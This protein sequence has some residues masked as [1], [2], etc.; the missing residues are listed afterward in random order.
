MLNSF[1]EIVINFFSVFPRDLAVFLLSMFP[2]GELKLSLPVGLLVYH[3]PIWQVVVLSIVGN[4]IPTTVI[5]F[6]ADRFHCW[7]EK[8]SGFF[9]KRWINTLAKIQKKFSGRYEKYGLIIL[10]LITSIPVPGSGAYAGALAALVF[11]ISVKKSLP[12]IFSGILLSTL[13]IILL[14]IGVD[15]VF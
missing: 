12:C 7:V 5:L 13:I 14:T 11:G 2:V 10:V 9:S 15:K 8:R 4:M 6:F 1:L 3:L